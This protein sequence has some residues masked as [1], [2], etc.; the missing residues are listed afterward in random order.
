MGLD[1]YGTELSQK[2]EIL[3]QL[4]DQYDDGRK[5]SF[6]CTAVN[7]LTLEEVTAA[8]VQAAEET[9]Q[10]APVKEK[11]LVMT[12]LLEEAASRLGISLRLRKK[13]KA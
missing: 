11:A 7:L 3:K 12:R 9:T 13:E 6:F 2:F 8:L 4:L 1:A 10:G 5:K